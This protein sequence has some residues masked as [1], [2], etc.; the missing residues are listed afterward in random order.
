MA[1]APRIVFM[2]SPDYALP[3]LKALVCEGYDVV[4]VYSQPPK[5]A[6]RGYKTQPTPVHAWALDKGF[7]VFTPKSFRKD[8]D[9]VQT[10]QSLKPDVI[11]TIAYGLLLPLSILNI[12]PHGCLNLHASL[13]PRWRGAAPLQRSILAGDTLTGVN[14]M[15][16]DE[17]LD[18][19][20]IV[21]ESTYPLSA[22]ENLKTLHDA[23]SE[24]SANL[25]INSLPDYLNGTLIP[26]PQPNVGVTYAKK[27]TKEDG[28]LDFTEPAWVLDRQLRAL[29]PW[30]G[31]YFIYK[32]NFIKVLEAQALSSSATNVPPGT[33]LDDN[34]TIQCG[35]NTVL[36]CQVIQK[37][38][39]KPMNAQNF[40]CGFSLKAG[41]RLL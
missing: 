35:N 23:L 17:D 16:M 26:E 34:L 11:I 33:V 3:T 18:T 39:K 22:S 19:G 38:G 4:G 5:P 29:K 31:T 24:L 36:C 12:P 15:I 20:P 14:L 27:V 7:S 25:L 9:A 10:L 32:N 21:A 30:P 40:L 28:L 8:A 2:G 13:L 37:P 1:Y 41:D 6:G